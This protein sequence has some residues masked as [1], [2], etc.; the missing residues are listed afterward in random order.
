MW[1]EVCVKELGS[2]GGEAVCGGW[3]SEV[4]RCGGEGDLWSEAATF[5]YPEV[6]QL[7][8]KVLEEVELIVVLDV[9]L[10]GVG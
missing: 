8:D 4:K 3:Q 5:T 10:V 9:H 6:S 2:V 1:S 7:L